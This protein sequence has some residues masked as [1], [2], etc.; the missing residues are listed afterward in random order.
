M[1]S[2][3]HSV[4]WVYTE[5]GS[6]HINIRIVTSR[7]LSGLQQK[8]RQRRSFTTSRNDKTRNACLSSI[9]TSL[10]FQA[11]KER[12]PFFA[13]IREG[14]IRQKWLNRLY[15]RL[16]CLL[17]VPWGV[18]FQWWWSLFSFSSH[19]TT[20]QESRMGIRFTAK[21]KTEELKISSNSE[22]QECEEREREKS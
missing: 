3:T 19:R 5:Y 1:N 14:N 10:T 18:S 20:Q 16:W 8:D 12:I 7:L 21:S 2:L 13:T 6:T 4:N 9:K 17:R 15:Q 22:L 11:G